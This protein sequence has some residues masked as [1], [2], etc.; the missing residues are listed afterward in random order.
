MMFESVDCY[1]DD[2]YGE[3]ELFM[4]RIIATMKDKSPEVMCVSYFVYGHMEN[5]SI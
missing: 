4:Y 3:I 5:Q 1:V 2:E